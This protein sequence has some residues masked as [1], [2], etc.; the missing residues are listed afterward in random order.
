MP[1]VVVDF[2]VQYLEV[3]T[4]VVRIKA[5]PMVGVHLVVPPH[6]PVVSPRIVSEPLNEKGEN[7]MGGG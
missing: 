4:V 3:V 5:V 2:V 7:K 6:T 1:A